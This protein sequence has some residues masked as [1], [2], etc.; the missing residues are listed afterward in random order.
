MT[1]T[2]AL[3]FGE[4]L[5]DRFP[6]RDLIGGAPFNLAYHLHKLGFNL[7]F[8]SA[9]GDDTLGKRVLEFFEQH[10]LSDRL[11]RTHPSLPT[12]EV[13]VVPGKAGSHTFQ[14]Q[15][16]AA[17]DA[18]NIPADESLSHIDLFA[19]G[20]LAL[21]H[22]QNRKCFSELS[23]KLPGSCYF[24]FD[25]NL[26]APFY[27]KETVELGLSAACSLKLNN[28]ELELLADMFGMQYASDR[29]M[30]KAFSDRFHLR[31]CYLTRGARGAALLRD[32]SWYEQ[33]SSADVLIADTVG[34]GDAF[35]AMALFCLFHHISET[36]TLKRSIAFAEQICRVSGALPHDSQIY[37]EYRDV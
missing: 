29:E 7:Q 32:G 9:I 12:G 23:E 6:D 8:L 31:A 11:L 14:I 19:F 26:R 35:S 15:D 13:T 30:L 10:G 28:D 20:T 16:P 21:R 27:C 18:I 22:E 1:A 36:E 5:F 2:S 25:V 37:K 3:V 4:V 24:F 33:T 34:A 17:Y